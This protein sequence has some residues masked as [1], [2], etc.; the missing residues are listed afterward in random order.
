MPIAGALTS[1]TAGTAIQSSQVNGNFTILR[2]TLNTYAVLTDVARTITA[3]HTFSGG[4]NIGTSTR[5]SAAATDVVLANA[6]AIRSVNAA[7]SDTVHV[8][9]LDSANVV[10]IG[11]TAVGAGT[12]AGFAANYYLRVRD[13]SGSD[14]YIPAMAATW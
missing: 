3:T 2:D 8:I 14:L 9:S 11:F 10:K 4:A 12:P 6:T 13:S 1:F 5:T 7:G